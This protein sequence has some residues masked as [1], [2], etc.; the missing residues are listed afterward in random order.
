MNRELLLR[1]MAEETKNTQELKASPDEI[2]LEL[3]KF[4]AVT[5]GYGKG[6]GSAGFTNKAAR[7]SE[8]YADSLLELFERC[9]TAV[10]KAPKS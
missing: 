10:R 4:I 6:V 8:E 7:T 3:M 5:T 2:A 9:R 1:Q